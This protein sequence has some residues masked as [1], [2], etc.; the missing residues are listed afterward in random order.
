MCAVFFKAPS[1]RNLSVKKKH[2]SA[3]ARVLVI[4]HRGDGKYLL[5]NKIATEI[6]T[7]VMVSVT[8][9]ANYMSLARDEIVVEQHLPLELPLD[10]S[11]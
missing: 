5:P 7:R 4:K 1:F 11:P 3:A 9:G 8:P 2:L 6:V 10:V